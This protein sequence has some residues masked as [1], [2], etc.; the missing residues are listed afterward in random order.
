LNAIVHGR[1]PS[2]A[3]I[4]RKAAGTSE[5]FADCF[6]M[7]GFSAIRRLPLPAFDE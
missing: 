4:A 6:R 1:V 5:S 7:I 3:R 2:D